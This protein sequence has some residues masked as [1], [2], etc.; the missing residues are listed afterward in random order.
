M[1]PCNGRG[2]RITCL[3]FLFSIQ[4]SLFFLSLQ[5]FLFLSA[6]S[7]TMILEN[8]VYSIRQPLAYIAK[9]VTSV[10]DYDTKCF[11]FFF[12]DDK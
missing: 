3:S 12:G 10:L 9:A 4:V 6:E 11:F 2:K 8:G 5:F 1:Q 7:K